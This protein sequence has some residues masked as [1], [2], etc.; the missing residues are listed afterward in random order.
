MSN[1][2]IPLATRMEMNTIPE[3]MSGCHL[4]I[5][6]ATPRGYGGIR[7]EG[8]RSRAHRVAWSLRYGPI[9]E[10][11]LVLHGCDNPACVNTDH[12]HI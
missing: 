10:G 12:L 2:R 11:A 4:W 9:P 8:R 5:G 6:A 3:P 7:V 1:C